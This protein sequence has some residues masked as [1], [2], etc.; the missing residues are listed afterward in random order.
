MLG[1]RLQARAVVALIVE[2][3]AAAN[4]LDAQLRQQCLDLTIKL[5]LAVIAARA[6]VA[7]V[8]WI[9]KFIG[10]NDAVADANLLR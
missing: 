10:G 8:I 4:H 7:N 5:A 2:V 1:R 6:V 3:G 9:L